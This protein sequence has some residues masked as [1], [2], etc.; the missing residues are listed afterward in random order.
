MYIERKID[1]FLHDWKNNKNR[2]PLIIKGARQVGKTA[3]ILKF[4]NTY[5]DNVIYLNFVEEPRYKAIV[6]EGFSVDNVVKL[7]SF[8]NPGFIFKPNETLIFFDELQEFPEITTTLKFFAI[9]GRFDVICSGSLLGIHYQRIQSISVGYKVDYQMYSL[10]FDEFLRAKGYDD[11]LIDE[12]MSSMLEVKPFSE[13]LMN[14]LRSLFIDHCV[15]GGMPAIV[16]NHLINGTFEGTLD[17]QRQII[18]DY[19]ADIRK[20]A[21][22]LDQTRILNVYNQIPIQLAKDNKKFQLSKITPGARFNDYWGCIEWLNDAGL[23]NICHCLKFPELPLKGNYDESKYKIYF[24]D[25]GLLVASLDDEAQMNL[26]VNKNLGIY[27][28]ALYENIIGETLVKSG[29]ELFYY[30]RNDSTLEM[31]FFM[32]TES[33]LV[34]IEVKAVSGNAKSLKTMITADKYPEIR[35]GIKL[36]NQNIGYQNNIYTFPHFCG[37]LLKRYLRER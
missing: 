13:T 35:W 6:D 15:L 34:P 37:F 24:A 33:E 5:Y 25:S 21:E 31:D 1:R 8:I 12:I 27:K 19:K 22:S 18:I 14:T 11:T 29:S 10:D 36:T 26:R 28:G 4:A 30:K 3:S 32:R 20:Y 23:I 9:D 16:R 2:L 17:M 7:I